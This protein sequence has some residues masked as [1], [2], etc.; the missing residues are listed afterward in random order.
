[1]KNID[2]Q[3]LDETIDRIVEVLHP[4]RIYLFG[5]HAYG[6]P[7]ADS[8][9]D[10]LVVVR[11]S[12]LPPH[13][14]AVAAYRTLRGLVFPAEIKVVTLEEFERRA[15]WLSSVERVVRE[16]GRILYDAAA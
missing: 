2:Q 11:D 7:H 10:I 9:I 3:M 5:S 14:R 1:M 8:D 12:D 6:Q 16:K 13:K 15:Q 4:E